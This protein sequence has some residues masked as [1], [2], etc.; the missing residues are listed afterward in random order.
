MKQAALLLFLCV[1]IAAPPAPGMDLLPV[2]D[3]SIREAHEV[4]MGWNGRDKDYARARRIYE[5]AAAAGEADGHYGLAT[6]YTRA[7]GVDRDYGKAIRHYEAA[8]ARGHVRATFNLGVIYHRALGVDRDDMRARYYFERASEAGL[9]NAFYVLGLFAEYGFAREAS[10]EEAVVLYRKAAE[11][12]F[13]SAG[14]RL[15]FLGDGG[16]DAGAVAIRLTGREE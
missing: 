4:H 11:L 2:A 7:Q 8:A 10:R 1:M 16:E 6:L 9:R 3:Y 13:A 12:G 14:L 15:R 5:Q